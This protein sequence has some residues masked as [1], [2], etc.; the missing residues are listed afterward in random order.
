MKPGTVAAHAWRI[1]LLLAG[2]A[3]YPV[4][5]GLD[6]LLKPRKLAQDTYVFIGRTEDITTAN[7][8]NIVNTAFIAT[9]EG[10]LVIDT[11]PSLLYGQQMR[12]AIAAVSDRPIVRVFNTHHHPDHFLG[13]QAYADVPI[14]ALPPTIEGLHRDGD[15]FAGNLYRMAGDWM[16]GTEVRLPTGEARPGR[17]ALGGHDIE[18]I[19]LR[20]HTQAD[21]LVFDHTTG[22][23]FA[24][25]LVFWQR[26]ATTPHADLTAWLQSLDAIE[27]LPYKLLVPGHGEPVPDARA[28]V[29]TRRYLTWLEQ[30]FQRAASAGL[31]MPEVMRTDLPS[32]FA[33][34]PLARSEFE[35]SV[36]HLYRAIEAQVLDAGPRARS[37]N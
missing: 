24:G 12:K 2:L 21:L 6:Y 32:E 18:L 35:R 23:L 1:A 11:G 10:V 22:V 9:R 30:T 16:R 7:G 13:N 37:G 36:S 27:R 33:A 14:E 20:G 19:A 3:I 26:T 25:D 17:F 8:G 4:E 28:I 34:V 29:Q 31:D 15:A 5:A